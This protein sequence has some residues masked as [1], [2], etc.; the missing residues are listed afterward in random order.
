MKIRIAI[1]LLLTAIIT[2]ALFALNVGSLQPAKPM[3]PPLPPAVQSVVDHAG[4][5]MKAELRVLQDN[6]NAEL[7]ASK[8]RKALVVAAQDRFTAAT[9]KVIAKFQAAVDAAKTE[10]TQKAPPKPVR[11]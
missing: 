8:N 2:T 4:Q 5:E 9:K 11:K 3:I 7:I 6:L 10:H 1:A